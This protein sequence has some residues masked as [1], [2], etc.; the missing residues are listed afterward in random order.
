MFP[1][2]FREIAGS[3]GDMCDFWKGSPGAGRDV[4]FDRGVTSW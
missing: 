3:R 4:H 2:V 1:F